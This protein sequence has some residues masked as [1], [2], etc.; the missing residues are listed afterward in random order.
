MTAF[1]VLCLSTNPTVCETHRVHV[2]A[3]ELQCLAQSQAVL[4]DYVRP[5]FTV[6]RFGCERVAG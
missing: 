5:G 1:I 3:T 4:A 2:T 6:Q